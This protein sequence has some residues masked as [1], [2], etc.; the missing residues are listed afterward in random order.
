VWFE[1]GEYKRSKR[2]DEKLWNDDE[3]VVYALENG[4]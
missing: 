1:D 4:V 2:S 3:D